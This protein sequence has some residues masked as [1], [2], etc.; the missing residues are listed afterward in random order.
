MELLLN[1]FVISVLSAA[2]EQPHCYAK[3]RVFCSGTAD[4]SPFLFCF[5]KQLVQL[6]IWGA[7]T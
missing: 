3:L 5:I 7:H 2:V 6:F 1:Y 4:T